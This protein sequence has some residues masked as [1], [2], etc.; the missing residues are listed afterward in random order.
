[1]SEATGQRPSVASY[2]PRHRRPEQ[3]DS[4]DPFVSPDP[5]AEKLRRWRQER[6]AATSA[7]GGVESPGAGVPDAGVVGVNGHGPAPGP[8]RID[9]QAAPA[10]EEFSRASA[11]AAE[12]PV[13]PREA[14]AATARPDVDEQATPITEQLRVTEKIETP[15]PERP[16]AAAQNPVRGEGV[17][18]DGVRAQSAAAPGLGP[19]APETETVTRT[20][21]GRFWAVPAAPPAPPPAAPTSAPFPPTPRTRAEHPVPGTPDVPAAIEVKNLHK[22][23]KD[24][25]AVA[26]VSFTVPAGSIVAL[27]GPNGAG[28]TTTVN[29]LCTLLKPDGGTAVVDGH[30]VITDA[31]AV[32]R[33]IMLTGQ[34]A[35]LDEA[36]SG[37][38]N[39][40]LFGRLLGL[41]KKQAR[42]RADELLETFGLTDAA[43]K[44]V[45]QYSGGMR[46]R[47][48]IAC[49][50]VTAPKVVFLDEPTTGLDPRSRLEVWS[51]VERMRASGIAVLLTTQYL[52]EADSM[53]DNIVVIDHGRVIASGTAD[54]L[55]AATGAA[56][57]EVTPTDVAMLPRIR[58][59]LAD[60]LGP[61]AHEEDGGTSVAVPAP[62]GPRTLAEVISRTEAAQIEL[63]D[64]ALRR[65]SLD[66]VFLALTG[67][68]RPTT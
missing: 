16:A 17:L 53:A 33:S 67:P 9:E 23:F 56:Y 25:V 11:E 51:L 4:G 31:A 26:D 40:V 32:R 38:E 37:R 24:T 57:C 12:V 30:D 44:R 7:V 13:P 29:M 59:C 27:L 64:I 2:A 66:E 19:V 58:E 18:S 28:K 21:S 48:D 20:P 60:L 22:R 41:N 52:E 45:G 65:P 34:F 62:D 42:A 63:S 49:G 54:E 55:K 35:A 39:L 50:L 3:S 14:D 8:L 46:R 36:L 43:N 5:V 68:E 47:V 61:H 10:P 1:M 15:R 6:D